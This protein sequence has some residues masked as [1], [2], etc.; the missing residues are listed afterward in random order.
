MK[1]DVASVMNGLRKSTARRSVEDPV[2]TLTNLPEIRPPE[3]EMS[4]I[5]APARPTKP[6]SKLR[7]FCA[8]IADNARAKR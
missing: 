6:P 7:R 1:P 4:G 8:W 2:G 3:I 5:E